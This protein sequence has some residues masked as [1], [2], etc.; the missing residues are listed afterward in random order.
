MN[1]NQD[2]GTNNG[3]IYSKFQERLRK[4]RL[5]RIKRKKQ[6][7]EFIQERV[8]EIR[9]VLGKTQP[10]KFRTKG[11]DSVAKGV[12][13]ENIK[14]DTVSK[15]IVDIRETSVD[16]NYSRKGV[17]AS[18]DKDNVVLGKNQSN[19]FD[20]NIN[21]NNN[22]VISNQKDIII[23]NDNKEDTRLEDIVKDIRT[24]KPKVRR[25]KRV[26]IGL[27]D[28]KDLSI[29]SKEKKQELLHEIGADII[30]KIKESFEDKLD[31][32]EVLESELFL[33]SEKQKSELELK[34]IKEIKTRINELIEKINL[35]I[36][37][38]NLYK[39]N[40]Y[41]DN[42]IG[43]DD[44][45]IVDDIIDYRNLLDS[46][47]DEK[48]F[49]KEYKALEEF[50]SLYSNL[51]E[52]KEETEKLQI[53]NEKKID[54]YEIRDKKYDNIKLGMVSVLD[55]DKKCSLEIERQNEKFKDLMSKVDV[56]NREE[57]VTTHLRGM[58]ELIS[59]S[60][61]YM[62]M[63]LISP[64][65]GMLPGIGV[66]TLAVRRMIGNAYRN[67]HLESVQ[68]IH[69]E[70]INYESEINRNLNDVNYIE[71]LVDDTLSDVKRLK[72]DFMR[73]YNS[74]IPGYEDTLKRINII[75]QKLLH[76]QNKV[77]LVKNNLKRSKKL[78][79]NKLKR[80]RELNEAEQKRAA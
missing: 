46:F 73:I 18:N 29:V 54:E 11:I 41:I 45:I 56:I 61:R 30:D 76:N 15:V 25:S 75:E 78:N 70:G 44:N 23:K 39:K 24:N 53:D 69:Y 58:G 65:T 3:G 60:L 7:E 17:M 28:K 10:A 21:V 79:E 35:I 6:N 72:E 77:S 52:I 48:S 19:V 12:T 26:G 51:V 43:I 57:Y 36:D 2:N 71:C 64:L 16:R 9:E 22:V 8:K 80:V 14:D 37:Q 68:H 5:S 40:Y 74:S 13:V 20:R 59:S 34:K 67:L 38:Y 62:G 55:I 42:V 33:L 27:E 50:K 66:Q 47:E 49:V 1:N 31:E 32:L 63:L 4:I